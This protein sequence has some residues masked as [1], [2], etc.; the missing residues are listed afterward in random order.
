MGVQSEALGLIF[1]R[2]FHSNIPAMKAYLLKECASSVFNQCPHQELPSIDAPAMKFHVN[3]KDMRPICLRTPASIPLHWQDQVYAE[4]ERDVALGVIEKVPYGEPI[5][6]CF[7]MVISRK[8]DGSPRRTVDL[9]PLNKF[10][11]R[12]VHPS[13]SPFR[14]VRS[15]PPGSVKTVFDAWNGFHLVLIPGGRNG[16]V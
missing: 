8:H 1:L 2:N 3:V 4:L 14:V 5:I 16:D 10:C 12:E 9:S 15:I 7:R 13:Q 11:E 6:W